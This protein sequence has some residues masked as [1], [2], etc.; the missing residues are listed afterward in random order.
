MVDSW[1]HLCCLLHIYFP[2]IHSVAVTPYHTYHTLWTWWICMLWNNSLYN[3]TFHDLYTCLPE[4]SQ[5]HLTKIHFYI[6]YIIHLIKEFM[7]PFNAFTLWISYNHFNLWNCV[8]I[9]LLYQIILG[10]YDH[11]NPWNYVWIM[12]L[13]KQFMSPS[14]VS[15]LSIYVNIRSLH[16][17]TLFS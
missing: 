12:H 14:N 17:W 3:S 8:R 15:I 10:L 1:N 11:C 6:V 13:V 9:M 5:T 4:I 16:S 7:I 2:T